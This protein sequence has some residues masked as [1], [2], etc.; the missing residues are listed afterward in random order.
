[1]GKPPK[2]EELEA[3]IFV[4]KRGFLVCS[5]EKGSN[6]LPCNPRMKQSWC[7]MTGQTEHGII[8]AGVLK[9]VYESNQTY[10]SKKN[11]NLKKLLIYTFITMTI[12]L[13]ISFLS[14]KSNLFL[15]MHVFIYFYCCSSTVVSIFLPSVPHPPPPTLYPTP[16][17]LCP[18]VLYTCSLTTLL[19]LSPVISLPP[20]LWLLSVC[21]LFQCL[22]SYFACLFVMLIRFHL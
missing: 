2:D 16:L 18:W 20:P 7:I 1:M 11:F 4:R 22:W 21:S 8:N 15:C 9:T 6:W 12:S 14:V 3:H 5:T 10:F 19:L 17:W 13:G